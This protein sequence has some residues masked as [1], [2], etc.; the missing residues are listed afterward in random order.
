MEECEGT[1]YDRYSKCPLNVSP[2][3]IRRGSIIKHLSK[4]VREKVVSDRMNVGQGV[5]DKHYDKRS[6]AQRAE[7]RRGYL[8]E[9]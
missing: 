9:V 1:R 2:H 5:L 6:E 3:A 7:Q 8:E 4:D